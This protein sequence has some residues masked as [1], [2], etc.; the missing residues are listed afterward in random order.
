MKIKIGL[1]LLLF[2]LTPLVLANE[3]IVN[4]GFESYTGSN[5]PT[6]WSS[7]GGI[8]WS[9]PSLTS[10]LGGSGT[11]APY[12]GS[13]M[14][15][16]APYGSAD[17]WIWQEVDFSGYTSATLSFMWRFDAIDRNEPDYGVD[18]LEVWIG[19]QDQQFIDIIWQYSI[20]LSPS[21]NHVIGDWIFASL[22]GDVSNLGKIIFT[23]RLLNMNP[24]G[25]GN[26]ETANFGQ[27][28]AI[29]LDDISIVATP[30]PASIL[31]MGTGIS[32]IGLAIWRR[33]K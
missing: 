17:T 14:G 3:L 23:F 6:D 1:A 9:T 8:V 19:K 2:S 15:A 11:I 29:Y 5:V 13:R 12:E 26:F 10:P 7:G 4:G 33:R 30:E 32:V 16:L 18:K 22:S 21:N 20:N 27:M 28:T 25:E 31:L 24:G